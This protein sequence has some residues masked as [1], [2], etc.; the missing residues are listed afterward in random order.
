LTFQIKLSSPRFKFRKI[1]VIF[2]VNC[3][4]LALFEKIVAEFIEYESPSRFL[5]KGSAENSV[6]NEG[7]F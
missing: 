6:F 7:K 1:R 2:F 3:V 5:V 4:R